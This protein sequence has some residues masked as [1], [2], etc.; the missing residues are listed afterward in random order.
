MAAVMAPMAN[1][2]LESRVARIEA[3]VAHISSDVTELKLDV[4]EIRKEMD[5][6]FSELDRKLIHG[7]TSNRVWMLLQSAALLAVMARAFKLL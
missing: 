3:D 2:P 7:L 1:E 5:R 6:R 4:R